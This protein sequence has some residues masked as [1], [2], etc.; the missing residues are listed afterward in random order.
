MSLAYKKALKKDPKLTPKD[1]TILT[2]KD[3][4]RTRQEFTQECDINRIVDQ[5]NRTGKLPYPGRKALGLYADVSELPDFKSSL[6]F[7]IY[8]KESF[9]RLDVN[10]RKRFHNDPQELLEFLKNPDNTE[11]AI[12]LGLAEKAP[13]PAAPASNGGGSTAPTPPEPA[14][15]PSNQPAQ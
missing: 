2:C 11:E 10:V 7:V 13:E 4:S 3:P 9:N 15:D 6:E 1:F 14:T 8:A 5:F 12:K